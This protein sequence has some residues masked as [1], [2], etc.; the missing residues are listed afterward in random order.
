MSH[1]PIYV[2]PPRTAGRDARLETTRRGTGDSRGR[3]ARE[4][5]EQNWFVGIRTPWTLSS[6]A[7]WRRTHD[8][9]GPLFKFAGLLALGA[10]AVPSLAV[11]FVVVPVVAVSLYAIVY[12]YVVYRGLDD[13]P[14]AAERE[15]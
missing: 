4:R 12:S 11:A 8:R 7:V 1:R 9:A 13:S 6:E 5:A 14:G 15:T 2:G 10:L 3:R